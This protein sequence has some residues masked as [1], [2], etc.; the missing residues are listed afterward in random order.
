MSEQLKVT[1][2]LNP[3]LY[4]RL[5][6]YRSKLMA[7]RGFVSRSAIFREALAAWLATKCGEKRREPAQAS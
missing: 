1:T 3:D 5:E 7:K 6:K 2:T 4:V